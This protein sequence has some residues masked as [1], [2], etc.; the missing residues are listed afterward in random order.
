MAEVYRRSH[1]P[2]IDRLIR[3]GVYA[4]RF[5][6]LDGTAGKVLPLDESAS[7]VLLASD[8]YRFSWFLYRL[9]LKL[10]EISPATTDA[11]LRELEDR[12]IAQFSAA[13]P[14]AVAASEEIWRHIIR[15]HIADL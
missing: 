10:A 9:A 13:D 6:A 3:L 8:L 5:I 4:D 11:E 12:L 2:R 1:G 7:P 15:D 14:T